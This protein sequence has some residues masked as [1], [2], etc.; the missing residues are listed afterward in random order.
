[1]SGK[2]GFGVPC[3]LGGIASAGMFAS[4]SNDLGSLAAVPLSADLL[5][6]GLMLIGVLLATVVGDAGRAAVALAISSVLGAMLYG[7][8]LAAPGL[9]VEEVRVT[10]IDRGTT[11]G[12]GAFFL[13]LVF[14]LIGMTIALLA[15]LL[16][17]RANM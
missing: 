11:M 15:A 16:L 2:L 14:G 6:P 4:A 5:L 9:R 7:L 3:V 17:G 10:L 8:A 13:I 12:L 1:M